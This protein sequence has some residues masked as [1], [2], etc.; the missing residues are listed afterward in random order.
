MRTMKHTFVLILWMI[1][2]TM[3]PA[4]EDLRN[5]RNMKSLDKAIEGNFENHPGLSHQKIDFSENR[6]RLVVWE[7][8]CE[9]S[10]RP[11]GWACI[12][13]AKGRQDYFDFLVLYDE[14]KEVVHLE[15]LQYR[16]S[17]GYQIDSK[18]WL[19]NFIGSSSRDTIKKGQQING[20]TGATMS[21]DGLIRK[22]NEIAEMIGEF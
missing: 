4:Q 16:S 9:N 15:I 21:V 13:Q 8:K 10:A 5:N 17:H 18:R 14:N 3:A 1:S 11:L 6:K 12:A 20:I 22:I 2:L 7:L 19:S